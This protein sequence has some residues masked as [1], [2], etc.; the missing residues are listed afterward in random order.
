MAHVMDI[1]SF[2]H[3]AVAGLLDTM[4]GQKSLL[5]TGEKGFQRVNL[6]RREDQ[7][8]VAIV[9]AMLQIWQFIAE[10]KH[11]ESPKDMVLIP[12]PHPDVSD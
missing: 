10:S 3:D 1:D 8:L 4:P 12:R 11:A 2:D 9:S 6:R 7:F 5:V